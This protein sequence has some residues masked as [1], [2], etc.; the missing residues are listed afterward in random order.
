MNK[1]G[2][3]AAHKYSSYLCVYSV[4]CREIVIGMCTVYSAVR[5]LFVCVQWTVQ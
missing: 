1:L 5:L 3:V 2:G 4:E